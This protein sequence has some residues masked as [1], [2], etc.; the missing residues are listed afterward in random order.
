LS[1]VSELLPIHWYPGIFK[2]RRDCITVTYDGVEFGF[3]YNF[4]VIKVEDLPWIKD[5][6]FK[7]PLSRTRKI[8]QR[9]KRADGLRL[10]IA[11]RNMDKSKRQ[12]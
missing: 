8:P 3:F 1:V 5:S 6:E 10:S 7:F 2:R 4:L 9:F 12:L 11:V